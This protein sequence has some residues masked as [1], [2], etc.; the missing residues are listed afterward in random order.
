[1]HDLV[2]VD[3][4]VTDGPGRC[5]VGFQRAASERD[6]VSLFTSADIVD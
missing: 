5:R 4:A 6:D 2:E 1:M 3:G